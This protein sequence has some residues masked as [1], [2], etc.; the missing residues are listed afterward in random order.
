VV[1]LA[2]LMTGAIVSNQGLFVSSIDQPGSPPEAKLCAVAKVAATDTPFTV[3]NVV[4]GKRHDMPILCHLSIGKK[5]RQIQIMTIYVILHLLE[6]LPI[7]NDGQDLEGIFVSYSPQASQVVGTC[8]AKITPWCEEVDECRAFTDGLQI[9]SAAA[10]Q[11]AA[12]RWWSAA[13]RR[14]HV[15]SLKCTDCNEHGEEEQ[16]VQKHAR[17]LSQEDS[18]GG[19]D[20]HAWKGVFDVKRCVIL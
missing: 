7:Q 8:G 1:G 15:T 11:R 14:Q 2:S 3:Q 13:G 20:W 18:K 9:V 17:V 4:G 12:E 10:Q 5:D 6:S 19:M 16:Q